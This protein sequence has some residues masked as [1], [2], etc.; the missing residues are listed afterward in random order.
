MFIVLRFSKIFYFN[1]KYL[2][3]DSLVKAV[4]SSIPVTL[5]TKGAPTL[6]DLR[7][8]FAVVRNEVRLSLDSI[9]FST[10]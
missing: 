10:I 5:Q 4:V 1:Y 8:R 2:A 3:E 6:P 7:A 9:V